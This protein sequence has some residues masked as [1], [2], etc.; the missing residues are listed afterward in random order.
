MVTCADHGG[1][2]LLVGDPSDAT[3]VIAA[4]IAGSS[5]PPPDTSRDDAGMDALPVRHLIYR[6]VD[7]GGSIRPA[8]PLVHVSDGQDAQHTS[9]G[10]NYDV[11]ASRLTA[12]TQRQQLPIAPGL[13][14]PT[15]RFIT[16]TRSR[17]CE[18]SACGAR[19]RVASV[20]A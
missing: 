7:D 6:T 18:A 15:I 10:V 8:G 4:W 3:A 9:G 1:G 19:S 20:P 11:V 14:S 12:A 2:G 5:A 16:E 13:L 17:Q